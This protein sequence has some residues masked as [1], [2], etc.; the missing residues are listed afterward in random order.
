MAKV[1]GKGMYLEAATNDISQYTNDS[2]FTRTGQKDETTGYGADDDDYEGTLRGGTFTAQGVYDSTA[3]VAPR[4]VFKG[5]TAT[6][7][8]MVRGPEGN[9]TGKPKES[10]NLLLEEYAESAP[11]AGMIKWSIKG[12]VAGGVTD[13]SF[14]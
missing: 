4:A 14:A 9:A 5:A 12:T 10:F 13:D 3:T 8:A 7:V 1:P 2:T 6:K 11:V